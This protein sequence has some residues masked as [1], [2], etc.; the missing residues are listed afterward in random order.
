MN[1]ISGKVVLAE[2]GI[3]IPDLLVVIHDVDPGTEPE[4]A[5]PGGVITDSIARVAP[6][7]RGI[8]DRLGSRL[9][10]A[11][12]TFSFEYEDDEF[13]VRN[14]EEKRPD[15]L[16]LVLAPEGPGIDDSKRILY[17]S[18]EIRQNAGRTEQY[19]IRIPTAALTNAD[20]S[21]PLDPSLARTNA[22]TV[23]GKLDQALGYHAEIETA[24]RAHATKKVADVRRQHD[25][26]A[27]V[28]ENRIVEA[29]LGMTSAEAERRRIVM[30][31][32]NPQ[33]MMLRTVE[34]NISQVVNTTPLVGYVVLDADQAA[35]FRAGA[36]W[37]TQ[38][39]KEEIEPYIYRADR[40]GKRPAFLLRNDSPTPSAGSTS[41]FLLPKDPPAET[42]ANGAGNGSSSSG[43]GSNGTNGESSDGVHLDAETLPHFVAKLVEPVTPSEEGVV[44]GDGRR[45]KTGDVEDSVQKLQL[46]SGP[47]DVAAYYDF[48]Q[49]QIAFDYVWQHALDQGAIDMAGELALALAE[50]GGD[51]VAATSSG[52]V[53]V[54]LKRET[55]IVERA[56]GALGTGG[57]IYRM[58][59]PV[60]P[61]GTELGELDPG[62]R[63]P[64]QPPPTDP[65]PPPSGNPFAV[66][67][68]GYQISTPRDMV[69]LLDQVLNEKYKFEVFAPGTTN[70]GLLV[71]YRQRWQPISYQ[72]GDLVKSLTL[73]PKEMC[74]VSSKRVVKK[75]R[76]VKEMEANLRN[77]KDETNETMRS[78]AEIVQKAQNKTNFNL[79]AKG[80]INTG[81]KSGEV[82]TSFTRD[83][84]ASSQDTKKSF[85]EAV[86]KASQEFKDER[87]LEVETKASDESEF[88]DSSEITNPNDELTV[89]YLFYELQR[90]YRVTEHLHKLMPVVFVAMEV[91][92]PNRDAIEKVIMTHSWIVNRVLLDDRYRAALD[93]LCTR[94]SGDLVL[95]RELATTVSTVKESVEHLRALED[96]A[97]RNLMDR[98]RAYEQALADRAD[99]INADYEDGA[100][101]N[102]WEKIA[103]H[104]DEKSMEALRVVEEARKDAY[105]RALRAEK[106]IRMRLDSEIAALTT[107]QEKYAQAQATYANWQLQIAALRTHFK[108][109]VLFYM[110]AIWNFT[111]RDQIFFQLSKVQVPK[112]E[113]PARTYE[114]VVP[115]VPP[116]SIVP[117]GD[118][119]V[120]E[121]HAGAAIE[122]NLD[123]VQDF[124][125]LAEVADLDSPLGYKG[126]YMIFP[127][128]QSNALT[129]FM[130]L[131]Y[132]DAELGLRDPDDLG[133]WTPE[134]FAEYAKRL[135]RQLRE[136]LTE[137]EYAK[138]Q[139]ELTQRYMRIVSNPR[140]TNEDII[141]PTTSLYIE[142]LP[143]SHPLL[144]DFKLAHRMIDVKK[145]Q[146]EVRK[147]EL[148]N[149]RYAA[150]LL[151][152]EYDDPEI[153][154]Q[155]R[156]HGSA[157][158]VVIPPEV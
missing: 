36:G 132:V 65:P 98:E 15:L 81:I 73:A 80:S 93:Y 150:R 59:E 112:L 7:S 42:P 35:Q 64:T 103:G 129:D 63:N 141:V 99:Q 8:G 107:V 28:V 126:N 50:Q 37:R 10:H 155:I 21:A 88:I 46:K 113:A 108:E 156:I 54:A 17:T 68:P 85:H 18:P 5:L 148:E 83:A 45:P 58:R 122:G 53:L 118:E 41:T 24:A 70:F 61:S 145:A 82:S 33:T 140:P 1:S 111:F 120:L 147:L 87:K 137:A 49:I 146:A 12:G 31:G 32:E 9:T 47:A 48:H 51:P 16:L 72:V 97:Q 106:D 74:K 136:E 119:I 127:L 153:E 142:A 75:E 44:F 86:L 26:T 91:P 4:E 76:S 139:D 79:S 151:D 158:N 14:P 154:R 67:I 149:L 101:R 62:P 100:A 55:N 25:V 115:A 110:Q 123:P 56:Q 6:A 13:R 92:N 121:V 143:G 69:G 2:T 152:H 71:T 134:E 11:D 95:M 19:L 157:E 78:E 89:T 30:P 102:A 34:D 117:A 133:A 130:M 27:K 116:V 57:V 84:E 29:M 135:Q 20:V 77:T 109:N 124:V 131:P 23:I 128:K 38:I 3:G 105:E 40:D 138:L 52:S 94:S 125:S 43:S 66:A 104:G 60:R 114:L 144:E 96:G 22:R 90:R 39:P